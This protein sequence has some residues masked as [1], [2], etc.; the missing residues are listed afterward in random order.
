MAI[1]PGARVM[2]GASILWYSTF[3]LWYS[4][5][6]FAASARN[7][8]TASAAGIDYLASPTPTVGTDR[9][10]GYNFNQYIVGAVVAGDPRKP[11]KPRKPVR[12]GIRDGTGRDSARPATDST[13]P[14]NIE[15]DLSLTRA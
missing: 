6:S 9:A 14:P 13:D 15:L 7:V 5:V 10:A 3:D 1:T 8:N 11:R 4:A 2:K 12:G